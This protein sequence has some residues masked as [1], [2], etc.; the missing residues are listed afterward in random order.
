MKLKSNRVIGLLT[1]ALFMGALAGCK[2]SGM[3][4]TKRGQLMKIS[5]EAPKQL[6]EGEPADIKATVRNAGVAGLSDVEID[7]EIPSQL[8]VVK[9]SHGNGMNLMESTGGEG[10]RMFTYRVGNIEAG[11]DSTVK[12]IVQGAFGSY[13]QSGN[14]RVTAWQSNLPGDKLV[15]TKFIK[16][17][18]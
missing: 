18:G 9:E 1:I 6:S 17:R 3:A 13:K 8:T 14:I 5:L 4:I 15:E 7:I 10:S 2:S 12:F 16:L 11:Q